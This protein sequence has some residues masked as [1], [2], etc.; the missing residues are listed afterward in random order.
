MSTILPSEIGGYEQIFV[1]KPHERYICKICIHPCHDAYLSGCCG[2]N[3]CK[4]CLDNLKKNTT[5]CPCCRNEDF[6]TVINKQADR[7]IKSLHVMCTNKERGCEWQGE[8]NDI[9]NHLE[10]SDGCQFED[11][12]CSNACG[13][14]VQRQYLTNHVE[15]E[16]PG[17][18]V[19]C[20]LC[21][22]VGRQQ[23]INGDHKEQCPKLPIFCPNKCKQTKIARED[24]E[25]HRKQCPLEMVQC[26]YHNVG[27]GE[28]MMRKRKRNHDKE[29]MKDHL[30]MT[31]HKLAKTEDKLVETE[32]KLA[33]N[34]GKLVTTEAKLTVTETR[35][36][37]LEVMVHR[38]I[39][40]T[41]SSA[42]LIE[43]SHWSTH[44]STLSMKVL[45]I[46]QICPVIIKM[47]NYAQ[48]KERDV[49]WVCEPFFSYNRGYK[50]SLQ[51]YAGGHSDGKGT[52]LAVFLYLMKGPHDDELNW[53][54]RGTFAVKLLNQVND[55]D[56]YLL[57][58]RYGNNT[59]ESSAGRLIDRE[60]HGGWGCQKFISNEVLHKV[61]PTCQYLKNDCI[62]FKVNKI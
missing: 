20:Q 4:S 26:D 43:S 48:Y 11:V 21:H 25:A 54:L 33:K 2:H 55:S 22:A 35:L 28:R 62:F 18:I 1:D 6:V 13:K 27:C 12:K 9:S 34:E 47:P 37:G 50:M 61:T 56:H 32:D 42:R 24:L 10:N 46:T 41:G 23:F 30:L 15:T 60:R 59:P 36:N 5:V 52:H 17:R 58:I 31:K 45:G 3:F 44:L 51:I 8:L 49:H 14:M 57:T 29:K 16:C 40:N 38:L 53:P 39:N 19:Q 7:E